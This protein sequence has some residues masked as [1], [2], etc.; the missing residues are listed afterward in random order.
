MLITPG[1]VRRGKEKARVHVNMQELRDFERVGGVGAIRA[2]G[3]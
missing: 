3:R 1:I 2:R